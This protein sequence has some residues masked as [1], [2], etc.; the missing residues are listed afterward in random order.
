MTIWVE[1]E[2]AGGAEFREFPSKAYTSLDAA[3]KTVLDTVHE[4]YKPRAGW[5]E[6]GGKH[7]LTIDGEVVWP[8]S[9]IFPVNLER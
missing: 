1:G 6:M 8:A 3:K 4:R 7:Y 2:L 5:K 9:V